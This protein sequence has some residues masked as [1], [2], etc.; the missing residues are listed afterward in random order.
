MQI[1]L[2][3]FCCGIALYAW[4]SWRRNPLYSLKSTLENA[5]VIL[6]GLALAV[7][8]SEL[9]AFH[10]PSQSLAVTLMG[11]MALISAITLGISAVSMRITDGPI[12]RVAAG[13]RPDNRNRRKLTPWFLGMGLVL[14]LLLGWAALVSPAD[15]DVPAGIAAVVLGVGAAALG[16]LYIKARR[17]DYA[18]AALKTNFWVHWQDS[19]G[20]GES[21]LGPD[22]LLCGGAYTPWLTSGNYLTDARVELGP[23]VSLLL[24]FEKAIG[25]RTAPVAVRVLVPEGRESDL[26]LLEGKLKARCPKARVHLG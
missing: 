20:Q 6:L 25:A 1:F 24:T 14:L 9:I 10:L 12:A 2:A 19:S 26:E 3:L 23:P 4:Q 16:G 11:I 17:T 13:T 7:G 5:A 15:A 8:F 18:S 21:W 22:G